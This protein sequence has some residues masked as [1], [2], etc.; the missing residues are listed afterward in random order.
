M[1]L[2]SN[3]HGVYLGDPRLEP[4]FAELGRRQAVVFL[5]PT[6]PVCWEQSAL[7]RPRPMV[8]FIFD[9]AR[10]VTDLLFAGTWNATRA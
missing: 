1:I 4:V 9:T 6:S 2:E 10:T 5:H 8:E 7:G 3:T